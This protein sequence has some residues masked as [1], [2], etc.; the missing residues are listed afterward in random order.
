MPTVVSGRILSSGYGANS[1]INQLFL[2]NDVGFR[3]KSAVWLVFT[4]YLI[5]VRWRARNSARFQSW[6]VRRCRQRNAPAHVYL[7]ARPRDDTGAGQYGGGRPGEK[8]RNL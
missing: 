3:S 8:R 5:I 7:G 1:T 6:L 2:Q 4:S